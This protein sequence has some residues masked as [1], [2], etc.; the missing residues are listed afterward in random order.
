[1]IMRFNYYGLNRTYCD[2]LDDMRRLLKVPNWQS[3]ETTVDTMKSLVEELQVCG[4]RM[5]ASLADLQ[6]LEELHQKIKEKKKELEDLT[7]V[8][9]SE[10]K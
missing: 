8:V 4:N 2:V 10:N 1:M 6:D 7:K 5:E 9:D 3:W